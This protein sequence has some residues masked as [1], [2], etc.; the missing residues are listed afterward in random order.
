M[1][2]LGCPHPLSSFDVEFQSYSK[3]IPL[4]F[5]PG[6]ETLFLS[7]QTLMLAMAVTRC[8]FTSAYSRQWSA[9]TYFDI[10]VACLIKIVLNFG[11][12]KD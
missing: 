10:S 2:A 9:V 6:T 3:L 1:N 5:T 7:F 4:S 8:E 12:Q 11:D